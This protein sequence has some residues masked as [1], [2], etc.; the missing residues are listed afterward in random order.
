MNINNVALSRDGCITGRLWQRRETEMHSYSF[1]VL[2]A[3]L[4]CLLSV[5]NPARAANIKRAQ[6][7]RVTPSSPNWP[8]KAEWAALNAS[9]SGRLIAPTPPGAVCHTARPEYNA[10]ACATVSSQ[11]GIEAFH[12]QDPVSVNYNDEACLPNNT[13]PCSNDPYPAYVI[14]A[15]NVNDIQEGVKFASRTGVRLI[16]KG[17]GHDYPGR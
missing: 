8:S 10:D 6:T 13:A 3:S 11:W 7:C 1:T 14:A 5:S 15:A 17:T 12:R 2:A 4:L 9:V 16:V